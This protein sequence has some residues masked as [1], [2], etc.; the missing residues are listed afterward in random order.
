MLAVPKASEGNAD[1]AN[2]RTITRMT[3]SPFALKFLKLSCW[4][5]TCVSSTEALKPLQKA[6]ADHGPKGQARPHQSQISTHLSVL[7]GKTDCVTIT[8]AILP[9]RKPGG[10]L[11][12]IY[13]VVQMQRKKRRIFPS[14]I[15]NNQ[16]SLLVF[17]KA[18]WDL[19]TENFP[20]CTVPNYHD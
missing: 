15:H 4:I 2:N 13:A 11:E 17:W 3:A 16:K 20:E 8:R 9:L 18:N 19:S 12:S 7:W 5:H 1:W 14:F 6:A 10:K